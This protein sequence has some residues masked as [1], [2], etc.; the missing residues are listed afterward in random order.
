MRTISNQFFSKDVLCEFENE[1]LGKE[2]NTYGKSTAF[3][4]R[5]LRV[6]KISVE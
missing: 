4:Q 5:I 2:V 3:T 6:E 1:R